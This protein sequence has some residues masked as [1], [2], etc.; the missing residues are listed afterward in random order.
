VLLDLASDMAL[1]LIG[2]TPVSTSPLFISANICID[3]FVP[4]GAN[5]V[6]FYSAFQIG[7]L[8]RALTLNRP[9]CFDLLC[10]AL[11]DG[12]RD[13]IPNNT[14]AL[15]YFEGKIERY[16]G[17]WQAILDAKEISATDKLH[18]LAASSSAHICLITSLFAQTI[19][20]Q[21]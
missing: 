3:D 1:E 14:Q 5:M 4:R 15:H 9:F 16:R 17:V 13:L 6:S 21:Q 20:Q 12:V 7:H 10:V 18:R 19:K 11:H 8:A 2:S